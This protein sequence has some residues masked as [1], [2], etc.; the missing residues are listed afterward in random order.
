MA[1]DLYVVQFTV[2]PGGK[3]KDPKPPSNKQTKKQETQ[4]KQKTQHKQTKNN[5]KQENGNVRL[6]LAVSVAAHGLTALYRPS[7]VWYRKPTRNR[8]KQK[9]KKPYKRSVH[10]YEATNHCAETQA[11]PSQEPRDH[12]EPPDRLVGAQ[13]S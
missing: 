3:Q 13:V 7:C 12:T 2:M 9:K 1:K 6:A 5:Q 10:K 8:H 4:N 11:P